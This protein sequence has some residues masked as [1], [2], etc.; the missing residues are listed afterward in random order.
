MCCEE[1]IRGDSSRCRDAEVSG[2][3]RDTDGRFFRARRSPV[4]SRPMNLVRRLSVIQIP[5][6]GVENIRGRIKYEF[7]ID[8]AWVYRRAIFEAVVNVKRILDAITKITFIISL[9]FSPSSTKMCNVDI[10][11]TQ[12]SAD[13]SETGAYPP[14]KKDREPSIRNI[15]Y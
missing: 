6:A 5:A 8:L 1:V 15:N 12:D 4:T 14:G 2:T 9:P 10:Y 3:G 13:S 11:L 7:G